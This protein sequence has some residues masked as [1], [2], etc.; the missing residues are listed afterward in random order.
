MQ[1]VIVYQHLPSTKGLLRYMGLCIL[2]NYQTSF[3]TWKIGL[4][5]HSNLYFYCA[6]LHMDFCYFACALEN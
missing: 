6:L 2:D 3:E 1:T 4:E 5:I